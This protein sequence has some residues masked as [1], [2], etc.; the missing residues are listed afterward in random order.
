M[1]Q[2][3]DIRDYV[4]VITGAAGGLAMY[5]D[6]LHSC[7]ISRKDHSVRVYDQEKPLLPKPFNCRPYSGERIFLKLI[8]REQVVSPWF[9]ADGKSW[10]KIN[11]CADVQTFCSHCDTA[12]LRPALFAFG[13]G[14]VTFRHFEVIPLETGI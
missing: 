2:N 12:W 13:E 7:G 8:Y 9:S 14:A 3:F 6:P 11:L 1:Y 5:Y 10:E 4:T